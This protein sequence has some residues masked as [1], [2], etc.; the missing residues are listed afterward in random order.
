MTTG[1]NHDIWLINLDEGTR[2]RFTY[3]YTSDGMA[4]SAD[5]K[6]LYFSTV[7]KPS[8]LIRKPVDGSAQETTILESAGIVHIS[9]VS[10][11]GRYMLVEE[12]YQRIPI[13]TLVVST[14]PGAAPHPITEYSGGGHQARFSPDG[15]WIVYSN[16]ETGRYELYATSVERGGKQQLTSTGGAMSHWA[17]D[18]KTIYYA[19]REGAVFALPV[20]VTSTTI[21]AGK[22]HALFSVGGLVPIAF[23]NTSFDATPDGKRFLLNTTGERPDQSRAVLMTNWPAKLK[24]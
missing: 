1:A 5:S 24:K 14:T 21:E 12:A 19:T 13:T 4:W 23:Y 20:T 6:Y 3:G 15:K 7:A 22:P 17:A 16:A 2:A 10:P 8:R 11:D 18:E 9:D